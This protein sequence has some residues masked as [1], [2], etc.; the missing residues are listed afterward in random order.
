MSS[1]VC[2]RYKKKI[3]SQFVKFLFYVILFCEGSG[4]E[5]VNTK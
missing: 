5:F 3:Q 4:A 2:Q 1:P